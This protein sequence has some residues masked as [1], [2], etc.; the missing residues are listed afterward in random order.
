MI[1][2][3]KAW[4]VIANYDSSGKARNPGTL[5]EGNGTIIFYEADGTIRESV[6]YINGEPVKR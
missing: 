3:G 4:T 2:S 6:S 1:Q 5:K